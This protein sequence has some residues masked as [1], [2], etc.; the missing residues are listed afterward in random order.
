[1]TILR[2]Y[3][4]PGLSKGLIEETSSK[5]QNTAGN[6][7]T[8]G[9]L[10]TERCFHVELTKGIYSTSWKHCPCTVVPV[11]VATLDRGHLL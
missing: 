11:L 1:M 3:K 5:L 2:Y 8:V 10:Q 4:V 9:L 7:Y 6:K